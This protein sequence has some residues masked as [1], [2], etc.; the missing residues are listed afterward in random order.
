M[1]KAGN[2][3]KTLTA[4]D[5]FKKY[6]LLIVQVNGDRPCTRK[7]RTMTKLKRETLH[8]CWNSTCFLQLWAILN[9]GLIISSIL[10]TPSW[11]ADRLDFLKDIVVW[12]N[13]SLYFFESYLFIY[14]FV[15]NMAQ[16]ASFCWGVKMGTMRPLRR[17][18]EVSQ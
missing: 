12:N 7:K 8:T 9:I 4:E 14:F 6:I 15:M 2:R 16:I 17:C 11:D 3:T 13:S 1:T 5:W 10:G 18:L